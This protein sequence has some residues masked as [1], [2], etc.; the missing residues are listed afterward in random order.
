MIEYIKGKIELKTDETI[1]VDAGA[2][3]YSVNTSLNTLAHAGNAGE[4]VKLFTYL[5]VREDAIMLYGFLTTEERA[6]FKMLL[7]VS[8]VGPKVAMAILSVCTPATFAMAVVTDDYEALSKAQGVGKKTAQ[9]IVLELKDKVNKIRKETFAQPEVYTADQ[10]N[11]NVVEA[12]NALIVLGYTKNEAAH[13]V[14]SVMGESETIE[15][16]IKQSLK[17]LTAMS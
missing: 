5:H 12:V 7:S 2:F 6:L 16:L 4:D 14:N 3:G 15:D 1:V 11:M 9:R 8:G 17:K 10:D 13:A